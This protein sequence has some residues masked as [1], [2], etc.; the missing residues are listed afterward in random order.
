MLTSGKAWSNKNRAQLYTE[1]NITPRKKVS[2]RKLSIIIK[3]DIIDNL[4]YLI[5]QFSLQ[6]SSDHV[7][8]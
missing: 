7:K 5:V 1:S 3:K 8:K 6:T 2:Y 4:Q